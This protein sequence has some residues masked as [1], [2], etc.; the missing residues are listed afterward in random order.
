MT[1]NI[2]RIDSVL[3]IIVGLALLSLILVLHGAMRWVGLVG[4]VPLLT[5]FLGTCP[6]YSILGISTCPLGARK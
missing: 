5:G 6:L 3:R 1:R 2:G 4:L